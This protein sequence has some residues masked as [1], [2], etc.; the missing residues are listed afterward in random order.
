MIEPA[1]A[2][3]RFMARSHHL[4]S[5][6]IG[7]GRHP[8]LKNSST[9]IYALGV[10]LVIASRVEWRGVNP[11][12]LWTVLCAGL[13][14]VLEALA[15]LVLPCLLWLTVWLGLAVLFAGLTTFC[16]GLCVGC[17]HRDGLVWL[18]LMLL[19]ECA[20]AAVVAIPVSLL[21]LHVG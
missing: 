1:Q 3:R 15:G 9:V 14:S 20:I 4:L 11:T 7:L 6:P 2:L 12:H 19:A 16:F 17:Q 21:L 13:P 10:L 5:R 8:C 18:W